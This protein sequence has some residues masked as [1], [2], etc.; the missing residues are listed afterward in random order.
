MAEAHIVLTG[1]Q[2]S[3]LARIE[4]QENN[5]ARIKE[6]NTQRYRDQV[7]DLDLTPT[8][9]KR[10]PAFTLEDDQ[11]PYLKVGEFTKVERDM[12]AGNNRPE[13]YGYVVETFGGNVRCRARS[14]SG[15]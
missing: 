8:T 12:S 1:N 6:A 14:R 5:L 9:P 3:A 13:G 10:K 11:R 15:K 2:A 7:V 4:R